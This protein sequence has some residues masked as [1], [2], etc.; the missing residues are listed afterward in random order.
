MQWV[1]Q[2]QALR[3]VTE[4]DHR[5]VAAGTLKH[6][7]KEWVSYCSVIQRLELRSSRTT[8]SRI[9]AASVGADGA[10]AAAGWRNG[11]ARAL[12]IGAVIQRRFAIQ[13]L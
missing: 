10:M 2:R 6:V 4:P 8:G 13:A 7:A 9:R 3:P 11:F 5:G 1:R 12:P